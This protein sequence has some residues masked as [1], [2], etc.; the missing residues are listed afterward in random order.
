V[1]AVAKE[2]EQDVVGA[3]PEQHH[4]EQRRQVGADVEAERLGGERDQRARRQEDERDRGDR[5]QR[6]DRAPK[7]RE[8]QSKD[9]ADGGDADR[10]LG[11]AVGVAVVELDRGVAGQPGLEPAAFEPLG[12]LAAH[13]LG[14][15][16][17]GIVAGVAGEAD[18]AELDPPV[19]RHLLTGPGLN[20]LD[21]VDA[22]RA[23]GTGGVG[24]RATVGRSQPCTIGAFVDEQRRRTGIA[25]E[26]LGGELV[27]LG[28]FV[29]GGQEAGLVGVGD[30]AELRREGNDDDRGQDPDGD[31]PPA[32]ADDELGE[33]L[34]HQWPP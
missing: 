24:D 11:R 15:V 32:A 6:R 21:A 2:C 26:G 17:D 33:L 9:Q 10:L 14:G 4:S 8:Q 28:R 3:D 12:G 25:G 13:L 19:R 20:V 31:D 16:E 30:V 34:E 23:D 5:Q 18:V 1:L 27:G 7:Q 29:G 22:A